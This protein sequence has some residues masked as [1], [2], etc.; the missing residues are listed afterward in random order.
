MPEKPIIVWF[1]QDLRL[2]DNPALYHAATK[3]VPVI[4]VFI[5]SPG[6]ESPWAPG[7][8]SKV[9]LHSSL[10][11]FGEQLHALGSR[12][13]LRN[14]NALEVLHDIIAKSGARTV[15]WNLRYEPQI[16]HRDNHIKEI[17]L[18]E[19][20]EVR[21][22]NANLLVDPEN[23]YNKEG[24]PYKV[25]T[26][27]Y[28]AA[29][30]RISIAKPLPLPGKILAPKKWPASETLASLDLSPRYDWA[31]GIQKHWSAG[32][33]SAHAQLNAFMEEGLTHYPEERDVP[34]SS[35]VSRMSPY[36]H[37]GEISPAQMLSA[38]QQHCAGEDTEAELECYVRQLY[39]RE[40]SYYLLRHFPRTP[41]HP[42]NE[43]FADFPWKENSALQEAWKQGR[44]GY[45]LVDAGMRELWET[46]WMHNRV[47][48]VAASF[49]VKHLLQPWTVGAHWFWDTLVDADLANN[50]MGWQWVAG[51]GADAAPYFRIFN[52]ITQS[53][54]FDSDGAYIRRWVPELKLLP[55]KWIHH[56][57]KS[58][59]DVLRE[60]GIDMGVEYPMPIVEHLK[61]RQRALDAYH[62]CPRGFSGICEKNA[63]CRKI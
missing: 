36:L 46:G 42:L 21:T 27:F 16:I 59:V 3:K 31:G 38:L 35:A 57:W 54:K 53:Q 19:G 28:K 12:L 41:L 25:F 43:K 44:T 48:M 45:P 39:W 1:R 37:H 20:I 14:G 4:P 32:E 47:R 24:N 9:W 55:D 62:A 33:V 40:F 29:L 18:A 5:W 23:F 13:I 17:L 7:S 58:P 26:P 2:A 50:T 30:E 22:F 60:S 56:P 63:F 8:A 15:H 61:A 6:E 51:C 49:L 34:S 52:P 11:K 10:G